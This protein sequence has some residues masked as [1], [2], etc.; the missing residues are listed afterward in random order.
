MTG[1]IANTEQFELCSRLITALRQVSDEHRALCLSPLSLADQ[2]ATYGYGYTDYGTWVDEMIELAKDA[3]AT[4][5][6]ITWAL[7]REA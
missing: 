1:L 3:G 2:R 4:I 5:D 7:S 6:Q